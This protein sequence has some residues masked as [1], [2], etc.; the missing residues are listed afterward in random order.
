MAQRFK[1]RIGLRCLLAAVS[2]TACVA[3]GLAFGQYSNQSSDYY[4]NSQLNWQSPAIH[5]QQARP[6]QATLPAR[7]ASSQFQLVQHVEPAYAPNLLPP[8]EIVNNSQP[9]P[10]I[11]G[12]RVAQVQGPPGTDAYR[13]TVYPDLGRP[14]SI[15]HPNSPGV[16]S[17][18]PSTQ[19]PTLGDG[20]INRPDAPPIIPKPNERIADCGDPRNIGVP[21]GQ[22]NVLIDI[23]IKWDDMK[24]CSINLDDYRPRQWQPTCFTYNASLLCTSSAYFEHVQVERYGHSWGPFLQPV[25]SAAH[26]YG[27]VLFLPYKMGLT[28]PTECVYTVGYYRP[29][30]CAP[31][32]ID[33][34]PLSL[35]AGVAQAG[36]VV[37]LAY[38]IP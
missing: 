37:G 17:P 12:T 8:T 29:G 7:T 4:T 26:F 2:V 21:I 18:A 33:P 38:A 13:D 31:Y 20:A 35:R 19:Y 24:P 10:P 6:S 9:Q 30:S 28:P 11:Y 14:G 3:T 23:D 16:V 22:V 32:M 15:S 1:K 34:V 5:G 36:T 25:M 27:S